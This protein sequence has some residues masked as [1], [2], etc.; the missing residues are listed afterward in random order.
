MSD[1][2]GS[3]S[4]GADPMFGLPDNDE[5]FAIWETTLRGNERL[6]AMTVSCAIKLRA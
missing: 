6:D 2:G 5:D 1:G 4:V 3:D